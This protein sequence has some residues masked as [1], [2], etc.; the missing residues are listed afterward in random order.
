MPEE[1]RRPVGRPPHAEGEAS[2]RLF[3]AVP[4]SQARAARRAADRAGQTLAAWLRA[5][6][7]RA[8]GR[9]ER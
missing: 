9:R 4:A 7:T 3:V 6:L 1:P 2:E 8:L 5:A